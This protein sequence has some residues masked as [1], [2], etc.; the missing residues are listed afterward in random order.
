MDEARPMFMNAMIN[1]A[2]QKLLPI[3]GGVLVRDKKTRL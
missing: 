1:I 3:H 2:D